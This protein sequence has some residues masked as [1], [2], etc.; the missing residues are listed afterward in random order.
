MKH[1][2][3]FLTLPSGAA[4]RKESRNDHINRELT[5][6]VERGW[7]PHQMTVN[8]PGMPGMSLALMMRK[9]VA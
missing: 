5:E 9:V 4:L 8:H 6:L 1:E 7:E 3:W 2:Y